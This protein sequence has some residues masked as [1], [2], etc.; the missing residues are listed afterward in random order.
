VKIAFDAKRL[1]NNFTGLGNYSRFVVNSL[2]DHTIGND[3]V[4]YTPKRRNHPEVNAIT[5][6]KQVSVVT[7]PSIYKYFG[8]GSVWR[9]WGIAKEPTLTD[10]QVFHGLSNELPSN[11]PPRIRK[12]VTVHDL[13]FL[14]F[15]M[16][17]NPIDVRI[18]KAKVNAACQAADRIVAISRQTA[19]DVINFLGIPDSKID[20]VYQGCHPQFKQ[21]KSKEEIEGGPAKV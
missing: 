14:R 13:I 2:L 15:P 19:D 9:T 16:F 20:I 1:F 5:D 4:L 10:A 8:A 17:Y 7:P 6:H 3:Y 12:I 18:Y 21:I 11:L